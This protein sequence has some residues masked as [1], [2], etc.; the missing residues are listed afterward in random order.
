[1]AKETKYW[2]I[3]TKLGNDGETSKKWVVHRVD[4]LVAQQLHLCWKHEASNTLWPFF[5]I[6][7]L[8]RATKAI[9]HVSYELRRVAKAETLQI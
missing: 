9:C 6:L 3:I 2:Q 8:I 5:C 7:I 4:S 1:M